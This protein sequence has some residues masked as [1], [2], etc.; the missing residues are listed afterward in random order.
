MADSRC[1]ELFTTGI[2]VKHLNDAV[3]KYVGLESESEL[4]CDPVEQG[5]V[6]RYAQAI[7]DDDAAYSAPGPANAKY[8]GPIAPA[9]FPTHMFR[10]PFGTPDDIQAHAH[11]PN[12]DGIGAAAAQG[13]PEIEPLKHLG[14]LNGGLEVE[15][16]RYARHGER[17]KLK[18]RYLDISEKETSKGSMVIVVIETEYRNGADELLLRVRRT[19][20]RR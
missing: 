4:A 18:S 1:G 20:L 6:R 14:L 19:Q 16:F 8:G 7:M 10:R 3:L 15:L 11:D 5:A 9:L 17:V 13:L 12:F 2:G